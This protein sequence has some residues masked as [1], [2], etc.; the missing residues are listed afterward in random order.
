MGILVRNASHGS[1]QIEQFL[2]VVV[3][4][5]GSVISA[6]TN[7]EFWHGDVAEL[8]HIMEQGVGCI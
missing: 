5:H 1:G 3:G 4:G 7:G 6:F 2:Q 8:F